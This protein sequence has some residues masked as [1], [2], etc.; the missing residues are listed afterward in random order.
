MKLRYRKMVLDDLSAAFAVRMSTIDNAITMEELERDYDITPQSLAEAMTSHVAGWLCEDSGTA[1]GFSI[2][3]RLNGEV[4]VV[5]VRPEY[6]GHGIGKNLLSR[7]QEW[8]FA[9]GHKEIWLRSNPDPTIR[10][11]GFY[12]RLGWQTTGREVGEDEV[13]IFPNPKS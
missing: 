10:A 9:E 2:G 11:Y 4:Q 7:V 8:L 3:D 5:V 6:E 12:R 13:L 1:V